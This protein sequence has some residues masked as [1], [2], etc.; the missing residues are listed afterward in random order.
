MSDKIQIKDAGF[1]KNVTVSRTGTSKN[2]L[3]SIHTMLLITKNIQLLCSTI[4]APK[5]TQNIAHIY[6]S[7]FSIYIYIY[8]YIEYLTGMQYIRKR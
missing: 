7:F 8:L 2:E 1:V 4:L 5:N 3:S 6:I